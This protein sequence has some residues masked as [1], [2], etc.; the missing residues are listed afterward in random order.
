MSYLKAASMGEALTFLADSQGCASVVAG[1]TDLYLQGMPDHVLDITAVPETRV[2]EEKGDLILLG[3][4]VT[5]SEAAAS[6]LLKDKALAL[7]EAC[8]LVGSPQIRNIG[9]LG[10][11]VINAAPAADAA[12]ALVALGAKAVFADLQG[13]TSE[14]EVEDLYKNFNR[15][16]VDCTR[17]IMVR[18]ILKA[19]GDGEGSAF[20]RF[21][22]RRALA[23]P[24]VNAAARVKVLDGFFQDVR[25]VIAPVKPAPTRLLEVENMLQGAPAEAETFRKIEAAATAEVEVRSSLLR[26]TA[27]YRSHL[28]GVLA[29]RVVRRAVKIALDRK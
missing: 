28:V 25:L 24:M 17:E 11:N 3:S 15:T 27:Q 23:L 12:V 1:A 9:T 19:C 2:L 20:E 6:A 4:A 29:A 10:G 14:L 16:K 8:S 7:A 21:A 22:S 5:H 18:L 13:E 26:C